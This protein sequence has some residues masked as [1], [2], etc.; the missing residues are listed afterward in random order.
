M[1]VAVA[2]FGL[3]VNLFQAKFKKSQ[4]A[5]GEVQNFL[6]ESFEGK[7]SIKNFHAELSFLKLFQDRTNFELQTFFSA[8]IGMAMTMPL[9]RLGL[10]LSLLW[11]AWIIKSES[12]S[13]STLIL[14]SGFLYL[15][16]EP[17]MLLSW[18]GMVFIRAKASWRRIEDLIQDLKQATKEEEIVRQLNASNDQELHFEFWG[19]YLKTNIKPL[20]WTSFIGETGVGKTKVLYEI[21]DILKSR[22][23]IISFVA[24]EPYLYNDTL[25]KNI[26]LGRIPSEQERQ[27]AYDLIQVFALSELGNNLNSVLGLEVGENGKRL[28]GGQIKRLALV[29]S[30]MAEADYLLWDDPFSSVDLILE[31]DIIQVLKKS[32]YLKNK[33]IILTTHRLSTLRYTDNVIFLDKSSSSITAEGLTTDWLQP[34]TVV[35]EYFEKQMV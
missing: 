26:F 23:K 1:F 2:I 33:T 5:Q 8:G 34:G 14:F 31:K 7:K 35:F 13:A 16:L 32:H 19:K 12:L 15:L 11:S 17:L 4:D 21:A 29:R 18:L 3:L 22:N 25:E 24:Q 20:E 30:L 27:V 6:I 9:V 10:G 28:S